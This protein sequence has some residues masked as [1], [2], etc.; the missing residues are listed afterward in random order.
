MPAF[1]A[2]VRA[3]GLSSA[4]LLQNIYSNHA[5]LQQGVSLAL[6]L[7]EKV[8]QGQGACRVHGGGFAG[9]IQAYVPTELVE[10]Y[11]ETLEQVLGQGSVYDLQIRPYGSIN[12]ANLL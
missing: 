7:S 3:S 12:L 5:P 1:F 6:A 8:L 11:R 10:K 9:T 2:V 4:L